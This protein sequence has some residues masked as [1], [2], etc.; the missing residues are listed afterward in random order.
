MV[1][2]RYALPAAGIGVVAAGGL[3]GWAL[4]RSWTGN[5]DP[6]EGRPVRL[7]V[8]DRRP[9]ALPDGAVID[10]VA[11]GDGPTVVLVHGLTASKRDWGPIAPALLDA[12]Y[13][14]LAVDQRG[15]GRSTTG[16]AGY[17]STQLAA[18]LDVVLAELDVS[19]AA[20]VGHSMGGMT[21]MAYAVHHVDAFRARVERL[22]L[23]AT[24]AS[25]GSARHR[26]GLTLGGVRIPAGV[27]PADERL[28]L[29]AGLGVFGRSPSLHMIDEAIDM[30]R[31]CPDEVRAEATAALR[32]HDVRKL[33]NR[34]E[35]PTL[36][37]GAG[38]DK[39]IR[40]FQVRALAKGIDGA[41][42][43]MFPDAG[44][45]VHWEHNAE[46]ARLIIDHLADRRD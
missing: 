26:L 7:P 31:Q 42:L 32:H 37:I 28:R 2:K 3:A 38:R 10:T 5:P 15:H 8:G 35:V 30:F 9:V 46:L 20:L 43:K 18:D 45:M 39:L 40:P 16:T 17:G 41:G 36:V 25:M 44:H 4:V 12:G 29:G 21:A 22:V 27:F 1:Q 19:A 13:R 14:V 11:I 6:L 24:A 34:I 33:L 23:V